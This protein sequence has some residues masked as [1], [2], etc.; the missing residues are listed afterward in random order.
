MTPEV[1]SKIAEWR[2]KAAAGTLTAD[3]MRQ[4]IV[5]LRAGRVGA[6]I[7]STKAKTARAKAEIPDANSMLD[8]MA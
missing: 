1:N 8:D 3:E 4:A 5:I 2:A 7:A 6:A